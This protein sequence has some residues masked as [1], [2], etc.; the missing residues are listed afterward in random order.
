MLA[1][2]TP[3]NV[4]N[5]SANSS[6]KSLSNDDSTCRRFRPKLR[7]ELASGALTIGT[8]MHIDDL[9]SKQTFM[10]AVWPFLK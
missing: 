1:K 7:N 5:D 10:V 2:L 4:L 3:G 6:S 9:Q 8:F